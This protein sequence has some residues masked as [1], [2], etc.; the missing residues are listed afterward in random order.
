MTDYIEPSWKPACDRIYYSDTAKYAKLVIWV[1]RSRRNGY[2]DDEIKAA[3]EAFELHHSYVDPWWPYLETILTKETT[4]ARGR[5]AE[6]DG[7]RRKI[8]ERA[9][10][11]SIANPR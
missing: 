2:S 3:L 6:E 4:R 8:E 11:K 10:L 5:Q 9:W 7:A 1:V